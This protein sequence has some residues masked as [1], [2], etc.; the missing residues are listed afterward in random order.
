MISRIML[1]TLCFQDMG[2]GLC[3]KHFISLIAELLRIFRETLRGISLT[4]ISCRHVLSRTFGKTKL[5]FHEQHRGT[6]ANPWIC[7]QCTLLYKPPTR[8]FRSLLIYIYICV[9]IY[10]FVNLFICLRISIYTLY[11]YICM[12]V[13]MDTHIC[14]LIY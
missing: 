2:H 13:C 6:F 9:F 4:R 10:L 7:M 12:Y 14:L 3:S 11:I 8:T 1:T 5:S